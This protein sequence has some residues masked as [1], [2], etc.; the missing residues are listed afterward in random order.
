MGLIGT[1]VIGLIVGLIARF[2]K[3]GDD[4]MG[5]IMT[6]LLGIGG[7]LLATYGGQA[8]GIYQ[9]GQTAGFIGAVVGAVILLVIY[10][11]VKKN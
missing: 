8:L 2:L 11:F 7:S 4:S 1:I 10:A 5:W 3:P 6:I 9:A